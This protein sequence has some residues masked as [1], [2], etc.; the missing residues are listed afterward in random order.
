MIRAAP[1]RATASTIARA[2][3]PAPSTHDALAGDLDTLRGQR[4]DEPGAV[5]AVAL[6]PP[7][8]ERHDRVDAAQRG[9]R[10]VELVDQRGDVLLVRHRHRETTEAEH[11]HR[12]ERGRGVARRDLERDVHPVDSGAPRSPALCNAGDRL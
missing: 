5:G 4:G 7:V 9:R 11:A 6:Q 10:R 2:A 12:V 8:A 1:P 3:P